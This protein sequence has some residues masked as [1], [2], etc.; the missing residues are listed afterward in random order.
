VRPA[1][2][3]LAVSATVL[4]AACGEEPPA[5]PAAPMVLLAVA[6]VQAA[7]TVDHVRHAAERGAPMREALPA[8]DDAAAT[9]L[10]AADDAEA[11]IGE[12]D[13]LAEGT[14]DLV[15]HAAAQGR[16]AAAVVADEAAY[17]RDL[18][19]ADEALEAALAAWD[20]PDAAAAQTQRLLRLVRDVEA[21]DVV[22]PGCPRLRDNRVRWAQLVAERT[23]RLGEVAAEGTVAR[24]A[25]LRDAYLRLP[26]GE[27][28]DD[29]DAADRACWWEHSSVA[30]HAE[31]VEV[32]MAEFERALS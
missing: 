17:L 1:F 32:W 9:L 10:V 31:L 12:I 28:R 14:H 4:A 18:A 5:D 3:V 13:G 30:R 29:A 26:F 2:A 8:L 6:V 24:H 15:A 21:L 11:V 22:P 27:D 7:D 19:A 20:D 23:Q 16:D 25:E